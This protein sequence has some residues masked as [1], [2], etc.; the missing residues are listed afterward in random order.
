MCVF[1]MIITPKKN[2]KVGLIME[3]YL[4]V[5]IENGTPSIWKYSVYPLES[6]N[7]KTNENTMKFSTST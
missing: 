1:V 2:A 4:D 7:S 3:S 6:E 5:S